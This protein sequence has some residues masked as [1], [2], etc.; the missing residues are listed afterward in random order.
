VAVITKLNVK[1]P[2]KPVVEDE[3]VEAQVTSKM[4]KEAP[5]KGKKK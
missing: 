2:P 1:P 4:S 3:P 5:K